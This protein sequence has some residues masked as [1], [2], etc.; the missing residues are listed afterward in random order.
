[1]F[2][3]TGIAKKLLQ[4][5][6]D[7]SYIQRDGTNAYHKYTYASAATVLE[8]VNCACTQAGIAVVDLDPFILETRER[9]TTKGN[10][11]LLVTV[12]VTITL[13]DSETGETA[14][15][16]GLG[17]GQDSGDKAVMK[18]Q[19]AAVKN[20]WLNGL[21]ISTGDDPEA[22]EKTDQTASLP[23]GSAVFVLKSAKTKCQDP[24]K[25]LAQVVDANGEIK[26]L[27]VAEKDAQAIL[28][29]KNNQ[30][31]SAKVIKR[32]GKDNTPVNIL[33]NVKKLAS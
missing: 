6:K 13:V 30:Q 33:T 28:E 17:S 27:W 3:K 23:S 11:E 14:V 21:V 32:A 5:M 29:L 25:V 26:N 19:T 4:V 10:Q 31:F 12:K 16:K 8:K 22:D 9:V 7:C 18:A 2:E 15:F 20:A 24:L 1:M